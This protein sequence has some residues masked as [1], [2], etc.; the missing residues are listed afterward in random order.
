MLSAIFTTLMALTT[1]NKVVQKSRYVQ[2]LYMNDVM[3]DT[4]GE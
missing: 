2:Y 3:D 4:Q 1:G